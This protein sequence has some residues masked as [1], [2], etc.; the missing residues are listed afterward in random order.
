MK[1]DKATLAQA[2]GALQLLENPFKAESH[3][4]IY[5]LAWDRAIEDAV[6]KLKELAK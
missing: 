6:A 1:L 3:M 4:A 5:V 2:I